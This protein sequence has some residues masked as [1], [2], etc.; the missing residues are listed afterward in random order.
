MDMTLDYFYGSEYEQITFFRISKML[1]PD[2]RF[3]GMSTDAKLL[4]GL[5]L[6]RMGLYVKKP[7]A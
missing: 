6:D 2:K 4:Y 7:L 5:M 1:F 3:K